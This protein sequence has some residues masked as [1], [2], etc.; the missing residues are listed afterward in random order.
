VCAQTASVGGEETESALLAT[1]NNDE[2][3]DAATTGSI[4]LDL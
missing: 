3:G 1:D 4:N 2:A